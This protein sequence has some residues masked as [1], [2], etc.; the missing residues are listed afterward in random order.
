MIDRL[1][2][3]EARTGNR[4]TSSHFKL[5]AVDAVARIILMVT[6]QTQQSQSMDN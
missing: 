1:D 4:Q 2:S 3:H 5:V 6:A